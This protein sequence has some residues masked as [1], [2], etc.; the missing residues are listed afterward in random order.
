MQLCVMIVITGAK[1]FIGSNLVKG[2]NDL[3]LTNLILVDENEKEAKNKNIQNLKYQQFIERTSFLTWLEQNAKQVDFIFHI[4]AKSATTETDINV[5]N[6]W[7]LNYSKSI[8]TLCTKNQIPLV[9]ASSAATYGD[10]T[11]G[12]DDNKSIDN[13]KP[14]N[15]YGESKQHFDLWVEAQE[16]KP[17]FWAGLKFFNV[18]GPRETHKQRMA[19]VVFHAFNQIQETG[20][21]KL[22]QSHKE[23]I[24]HGEQMRDF[25][26]V[27]DIVLVCLFLY[28][29]QKHS[30]IYNVGTGKARSFNDL[31]KAVFKAMGV[32]EN[33]SYIP[34]PIDIRDKYQYFTEATMSKLKKAGYNKEFTSLEDGV[35][36]YVQNYL[37]K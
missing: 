17:P 21:M 25:I 33:I 5:L 7:N 31:T 30:G 27:K 23:G 26:Y 22:F 1:G 2:L 10:G 18:Y 16:E 24:A 4:G 28:E 15:L 34:T 35:T 9:Y 6:K 8:F 32:Q 12:Y 37:M 14:L 36:E 13:L 20:A 19:S 3:N 11:L 29:Q